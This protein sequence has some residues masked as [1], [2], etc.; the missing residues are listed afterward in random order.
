MKNGTE[1]GKLESYFQAFTKFF[2]RIGAGVLVC[3]MLL[4]TFDVV[5]RYFFNKPVQGT[6]ELVEVMMGVVVSLSIAYCGL[7]RGHVSVELL[8]DQLSVKPRRIVDIIHTVVCIV[9]F[10]A[11]SFKVSQQAVVI[12]ES[13]TVTV[14]LEI[15][16]Y[17]FLWILSFGAALL[18]L[19][20]FSQLIHM[21]KKELSQ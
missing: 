17:P 10:A 13:E 12:K 14:L 3:M 11:V 19:V 21:F 1:L 20:Y 8:T 18:A 6:F 7:Q 9:F 5:S 16:I 15:P 4:I 2:S